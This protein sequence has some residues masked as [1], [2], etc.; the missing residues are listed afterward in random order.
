MGFS[1]PSWLVIFR[2]MNLCE[3]S[4]GKSIGT[5]AEKQ[6]ENEAHRKLDW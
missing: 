3:A 6:E 2:K 4:F 5:K 1:K